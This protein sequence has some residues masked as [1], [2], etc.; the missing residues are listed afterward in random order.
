MRAETPSLN[1]DKATIP[2]RVSALALICPSF[3]TLLEHTEGVLSSSSVLLWVDSQDV[4]LNS[5]G[6]W[7]INIH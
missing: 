7:S 6:E 2:L 3:L 5:L 4:E 1:N